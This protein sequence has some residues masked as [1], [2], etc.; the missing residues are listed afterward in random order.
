K[1]RVQNTLDHRVAAFVN[2]D[3]GFVGKLGTA[4]I[5]LVRPLGQSGQNIEFADGVCG[6][7]Q[8]AKVL[9]DA[10]DQFVVQPFFPGQCATSGGQ[11]L[12]FEDLQFGSDK[13]LGVF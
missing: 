11:C 3:S 10:L 12:V 6:I 7:L 13:T 8:W 5:Q 1:R 4:V 9:V 2:M